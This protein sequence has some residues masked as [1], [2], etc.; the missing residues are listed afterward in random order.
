[1]PLLL[2]FIVLPLAELV[3]FGTVSARIGG[4]NALLLCVLAA[5]LGGVLIQRQGLK[6][7]AALR[8]SL[9]HN[10]IPLTEIFDGFCIAT[11]GILLIIPG[12]ITDLI[13]ILL[14]LP[15]MRH[16]ARG[17][18][19]N[20]TEYDAYTSAGNFSERRPRSDL[21]II[22]GEFESIEPDKNMLDPPA[23]KRDKEP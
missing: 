4:L 5:I 22:E 18:I 19:K 1:M 17:F 2:L 10:Q 7:L 9:Q 8:E 3:V 21:D 12:F 23:A 11:A 20:H 16:I 14:L 13:G 6:T 15:Y